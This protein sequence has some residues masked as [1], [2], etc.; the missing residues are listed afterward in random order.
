MTSI[1]SCMAAA[2]VASL[3]TL[4]YIKFGRARVLNWGAT[5][6]EAQ[7]VLPGDEILDDVAIQT[8]RAI[9]VEAPPE[10][11]WPWLV[12]MGPTPRAGVYTYDWIERR[13]GIDIENSDR[14]L[15][16]Y[17]HLEVGEYF[18]L[19]ARKDNGLTVRQVEERRALVLQW[20]PA[21]S[22]WAF[23]LVP[24][25]DGS[26]RLISR[27][28]L[29]GSGPLFWLGMVFAMEPGSLVMEQ[30][31]LKGIKRRAEV[32]AG[33][34]SAAPVA[35]AGLPVEQISPSERSG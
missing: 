32:L 29:P 22:T 6:G 18:P 30:K 27:N 10:A 20:T 7:A 5:P 19:N 3:A 31:M 8:T 33:K 16:E 24:R 11:I 21:R 9:T 1:R 17:Q 14:I 35:A 2:G 15:P 34:G 26:T 4:G 13:L 25:E 23:V 28:R 12:Q